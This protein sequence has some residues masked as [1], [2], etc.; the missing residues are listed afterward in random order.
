MS[1]LHQIGK[2]ITLALSPLREAVR[3]IETF[4][5]F[6]YRLGWEADDMPPAYQQ[7]STQIENLV[8]QLKSMGQQ[9]GPD[10]ITGFLSTIRSA[11][12]SLENIQSAPA[13]VADVNVF[14]QEIRIR[15]FEILLVDYLTEVAPFVLNFFKMS[16]VIEEEF[17]PS[18]EGSNRPSFIRSKFLWEKIPEII[19]H[20]DSL[21]ELIYGWG[22]DHFDFNLFASHALE[23]FYALRIP[24]SYAPV[25]KNIGEGYLLE[26]EDTDD[27]FLPS[28]KYAINLP[29]AYL[30]IGEDDKEI[31]ISILDLPAVEDK[32]PGIILQP[33][34]PSEISLPSIRM[35]EDVNLLIKAGT[36]IATL[37]GLMI[38][39]GNISVAYPFKD[40]RLP[41][42]GFG[43]GAEYTP[44]NTTFL[45]GDETSSR[46]QLKGASL[47][48]D[49]IFNGQE[50][51][52]KLIGVLKDFT[53]VI[54]PSSSDNFI[55]K[56]LGGK[57]QEIPINLGF[58]WSN[59]FG[60]KF[61]GGG[62]FEVTTYPHLALGPI[63]IEQLLLRLYSKEDPIPNIQLQAG[64]S[65]KA[66]LG[67]V[68]MIVEG[69]GLTLDSK[70]IRGNLG[71]LDLNI[72]IKPPSGVGIS[73]EGGGF[74]GGGFLKFD[75]DKKEYTGALELSFKDKIGLKAIGILNTK[76]PDGSKGYSLLIIITAEFNPIQLGLGFTLNGVGGLLGLHRTFLIEPLQKGIY[77]GSLSNIL[78][79][80]N[81]VANAPVIISQLQTVF[82]AQENHFLIGPMAK[83]GWG[84][85]TIMTLD[86]GLL[87]EIPR[88]G[89]ALLGIFR[90]VLPNPE[91][92]IV[93]V[94]VDFVGYF[95][96]EKGQ[97]S[98]DGA[99]VDSKIL[100]YTLTGNMA[101]RL[102]YKDQ[103][104]FLLSIG[105]FH[106]A[107]TPPPMNLPELKRI[108]IVIFSGNPSL[109]TESYMAVTSNTIQF[110]SKAEL[111]YSFKVFNVY[112]F[113]SYDV[114]IQLSPLYFIADF[115]A[116]LA[117]R[118]G[119]TV[120]F[121]IKV[122]LILEGPTPWH[123][124][125]DASFE[126]GFIIS[127]TIKVHFDVTIGEKRNNA[128]DTI[129]VMP[130][131]ID[132]LGDLQNW[133]SGHSD[134]MQSVSYRKPNNDELVLEPSGSLI[135]TQ[136]I[137]PLNFT[138]NKLGHHALTGQ[139]FFKIEE[140]KIENLSVSP[141]YIGDLF[142]PAQY[143]QMSDGDK[144]SRPSFEEMDAGIEIGNARDRNTDYAVKTD[145]QYEM[146]YIP[147]KQTKR[148][149]KMDKNLFDTLAEENAV[150][151]SIVNKHIHKTNPIATA[152]I[153]IL[154]N[155]YKIVDN[156]NMKEIIPDKRFE[157]MADAQYQLQ[158]LIS[159][160]KKL[161]S[162]LQ[163]IE[164]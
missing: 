13:G 156:E 164:I 146:V 95:D 136:K 48:L 154:K 147:R 90:L 153:R 124:S 24:V 2:H 74:T 57:K 157:S 92:P 17:I 143:V 161:K 130:L 42:A 67:P 11:Y 55:Q 110:G 15:L 142:A 131:L 18:P 141:S 45:I 139:H 26:T 66:N 96:L 52:I 100:S 5:S 68:Q 148:K 50:F 16:G 60:L 99:L 47:E 56:I 133:S 38:R 144:L 103:P 78:F 65:I 113:L 80:Q 54:D 97:I 3:D 160:N 112:G 84:T 71:P 109:K 118:S 117:V 7:I 8:N 36:N 27:F 29:F 85:P 33:N 62:G 82:P 107:F 14:L 145:V 88:P 116:M 91:A 135:I 151:K 46:L 64:A 61:T 101:F 37:F 123:A 162:S 94:R 76:M 87:I 163:I 104:S 120:L 41:A 32:K 155:Q 83:I 159:S 93:K 149:I 49:F 23:L 111:S 70:F 12:S 81:I 105:G 126:I 20:P 108:S 119:S 40:G 21:P 106:P 30:Q 102:Y 98:I 73:I 59:K 4:K 9:P 137:V 122:H 138:I 152:P 43:A 28:V 125:G 44:V 132:A 34:I 25:P 158:T 115:Q 31:G 79:P 89:F 1:T 69:L 53:L 128:L 19:K 86:L 75:V 134:V 10:Q 63:S 39:P 58:E 22:T 72:G 127:V 150:S 6:M 140:L 77:D 51:E 114:L 121:S 35:R 129:A